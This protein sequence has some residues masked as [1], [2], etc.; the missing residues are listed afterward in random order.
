MATMKALVLNGA[1]DFSLVDREIPQPAPN[2]VLIKIMAA[3]IC[4][5]DVHIYHGNASDGNTA[6]LPVILGHE[7]SG[8]VVALGSAVT[9]LKVGDR[10]SVD[11][12]VYCGYCEFCR[13]NNIHLCKNNSCFGI[14]ADGG[15]AQYGVIHEN[16]AYKLPDEV[17]WLEGAMIEPAACCLHGADLAKYVTG[18]SVL[19]HGAG[20]IGNFHIQFAKLRGVSTI[21]VSDPIA[22]RRE[23]ALKMGADYVFDPLT[24]NLYEEVRKILPDG[25]RVIMDCS[26]RPD[27]VE[28]SIRQVRFGGTVVLFGICPSECEIK[29]NPSYVNGRE[30]TICGSYDYINAHQPSIDAIANKRLSVHPLISHVFALEDYEKAFATFGTKD[31]M[32][33]VITPNGPVE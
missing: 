30:I 15:F 28:E 33:I 19:I 5:T 2:E 13:S 12:N 32:K 29:I 31:S 27:V 16:F 24:Q 26:G 22:S 6:K 9:S 14:T 8:E 20:A 7:V 4:G 18:D 23:L 17:S 25:P 10:V 1:Y 21:I 11:P 3:G